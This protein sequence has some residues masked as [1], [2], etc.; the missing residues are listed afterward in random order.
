MARYSPV[1]FHAKFLVV[2]TKINIADFMQNTGSTAILRALYWFH[3]K[4]PESWSG[5]A[6]LTFIT[7]WEAIVM[8]GI[9]GDRAKQSRRKGGAVQLSAPISDA[10]EPPANQFKWKC[11][12]LTISRCQL[13]QA[14]DMRVSTS[15]FFLFALCF[16]IVPI[17]LGPSGLLNSKR[18][19][20]LLWP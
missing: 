11:K 2:Q 18:G 14:G 10:D 9:S 5:T 12:T 17:V 13:L 19:C 15:F 16:I 6:T 20:T 1:L 8:P 7:L 4:K 3:H